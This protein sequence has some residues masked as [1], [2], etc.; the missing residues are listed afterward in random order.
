MHI[1]HSPTSLLLLMQCDTEAEHR[2][3]F[4]FVAYVVDG[5]HI[6]CRYRCTNK[7]QHK[8]QND[9]CIRSHFAFIAAHG[10]VLFR[11]RLFSV[12]TIWIFFCV[13]FFSQIFVFIKSLTF[14]GLRVWILCC[15]IIL[16]LHTHSLVPRATDLMPKLSHS[17]TIFSS[18]F[19]E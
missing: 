2:V 13:L 16:N 3:D 10:G 9:S 17:F 7:R 8:S 6:E 19:V 4:T 11:R 1:A 5:I 15:L 18:N 12:E 14:I